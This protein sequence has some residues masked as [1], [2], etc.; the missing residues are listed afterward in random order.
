MAEV[1]ERK[2]RAKEREELLLEAFESSND[3]LERHDY[4]KL[5]ELAR[6]RRTDKEFAEAVDLPFDLMAEGVKMHYKTPDI[7]I[8]YPSFRTY[9]VPK[10]IQKKMITVV[11]NT[12]FQWKGTEAQYGEFVALAASYYVG[13]GREDGFLVKARY[14]R[15][16]LVPDDLQL[17]FVPYREIFINGKD[18]EKGARVGLYRR[19]V[20]GGQ[21]YTGIFDDLFT[22]T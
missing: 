3:A 16:H 18:L 13:D 15:G 2:S 6:R 11:T 10:L 17:Q 21:T 20:N 22:N 14:R 1:E 8:K 7:F 9:I 5:E 4:A 19:G 12:L